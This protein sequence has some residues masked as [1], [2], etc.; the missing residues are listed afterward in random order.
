MF[1]KG[2]MNVCIEYTEARKLYALNI[3]PTLCFMLLDNGAAIFRD[4]HEIINQL[5]IVPSV[6]R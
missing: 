1:R 6:I 4:M 5:L 3:A 2:F